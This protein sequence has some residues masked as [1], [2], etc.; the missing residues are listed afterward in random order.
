[1]ARTSRNNMR[2][3]S[4]FHIMVQGIN[5][6]EIFSKKEFKVKYEK[7]I[8]KLNCGI[9]IIAYCIMN[10]H[11][12]I[13][14]KT[15]EIKF[16]QKWMK[17]VN[18]IFAMEYNKKC[19]RIGYVFRDRYKVQPIMD[20]KHLYLCAEYIHNNPVK[21]KSCKNKG[22]YEYSSYVKLYDENNLELMNNIS[23]IL[24][25]VS[26]LKEIVKDDIEKIDFLED[27]SEN[28]EEKC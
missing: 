9:E 20:V 13:L 27:D 6:E 3:S 21:A 26:K 7:L 23:R 24:Q 22:D 18:T 16:I 19:N 5:K 1:M 25:D 4:F 15:D 17:K 8:F 14:I 2:S 10:N 11:A 12:H 28:K